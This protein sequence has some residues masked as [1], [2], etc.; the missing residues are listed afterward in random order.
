MRSKPESY[1]TLS[2]TISVISANSE[3][4]FPK[5]AIRMAE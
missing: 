2:M 5:I 3:A 4:I 1:L